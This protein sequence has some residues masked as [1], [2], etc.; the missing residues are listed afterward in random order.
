MINVFIFHGTEGKPESNW[1]LWLKERLQCEKC[2]VVV[3][4]FPT[5]DGQTLENWLKVFQQYEN[6]VSEDTIFVGHSLGG[7]FML[8]LLEKH[9]IKMAVFVA[10]F[11]SLLGNRFDDVISTFVKDLSVGSRGFDWQKIHENCRKFLVFHSDND[12]YVKTEI[13]E[14]LAEN[15]G[16]GVTFVKGAGHFNGSAGYGEFPL[17]LETLKNELT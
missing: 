6:E 8:S 4:K 7:L 16:V 9:K 3:P 10:S 17:L 5:P 15:L 1:F 11:S 13:A 14:K 2:N 12:P